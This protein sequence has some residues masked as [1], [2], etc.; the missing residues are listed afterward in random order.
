V[1]SYWLWGDIIRKNV[2]LDSSAIIMCFEFSIDLEKELA[3]IL[4]SFDIVVP[5]TVVKELDFLSKEGK[6]VKKIKAKASLKLIEKYEIIGVDGNNADDSLIRLAKIINGIVV[7]ND[8][9]LRKRLKEVFVPVVFLRSK[10]KLIL[11]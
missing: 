6:G 1:A 4:G 9:D 11:E 8:K 7:T 10:K 3:R 5:S 2:I